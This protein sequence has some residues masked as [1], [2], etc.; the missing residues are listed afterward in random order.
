MTWGRRASL[1]GAMAG[2]IAFLLL[3]PFNCETDHAR[4]VPG[5][6]ETESVS[7]NCRGIAAF[8]YQQSEELVGPNEPKGGVLPR[9]SL[10]Q[11]QAAITAIVIGGLVALLVWLVGDRPRTGRPARWALTPFLLGASFVSAIDPG[12]LVIYSAPILLPVIWWLALESGVVA[13]TMWALVAGFLSVEAVAL[14]TY[15]TT[16]ALVAPLLLVVGSAVVVL[17]MG[18]PRWSSRRSPDFPLTLRG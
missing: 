17:I 15:G 18:A 9:P 7:T 2:F 6:W 14:V 11:P 10:L 3:A 4:F 1:A 16:T 8:H 5:G 13:R 12:G